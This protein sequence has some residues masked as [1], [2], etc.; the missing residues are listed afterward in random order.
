MTRA[1]TPASFYSADRYSAD[2]SVG[3]L[4]RRVLTGMAQATDVRLE[5][6][7]LT[8]AQWVPLFKLRLGAAVTVAELARECQADAGSM[9]RMLDRLEAKGL[10]RRVRSTEDRRVVNIELTAEGERV[11]D[12]VPPAIADVLNGYLAGFSQ[13]EWETLKDML[14]RMLENAATVRQPR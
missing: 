6:H 4:M 12:K 2:E 14:R 3:Y 1:R 9:T 11:A 7:G 10:C 8:N 13:P 5:P